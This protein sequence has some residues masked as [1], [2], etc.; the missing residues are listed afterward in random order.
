MSRRVFDVKRN[1]ARK[2][3]W[4][5]PCPCP[6][7]TMRPSLPL[8]LVALL[9][10]SIPASFAS[11]TEKRSYDTH[12]YFVL[13]HD[14]SAGLPL[15]H[16]LVALNLELVEQVGQLRNHWLLRT[17]INERKRRR[18]TLF[19]P[20]DSLSRLLRSRRDQTGFVASSHDN[21]LFRL[22]P[23]VKHFS[24]QK[25]RRRIKRT[26]LQLRAPPEINNDTS[27]A[28]AKRLDIVDPTFHDQWHLVNDEFPSHSV[29]V[30]PVWD[31]GITG[32]GIIA[33]MVDD[34]LD[35]E[36]DDLAANFVRFVSVLIQ[37]L[38]SSLGRCELLR[39]QSSCTT[40]K[41]RVVR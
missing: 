41:A 10:S 25:P 18:D 37:N 11:N 28:V 20:L 22:L 34:G 5:A 21:D 19:D 26:D 23:A 17:A 3:E 7:T 30:A 35:Y 1:F 14:P 2:M 6:A 29:N 36:S 40:S 39:F 31:M 27:A 4:T 15:N 32:E 13:E 16:L 33:A 24:Q 12:D 38:T 9:L 8:A